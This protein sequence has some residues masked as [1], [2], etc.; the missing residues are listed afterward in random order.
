MTPPLLNMKQ[1]GNPNRCSRKKGNRENIAVEFQFRKSQNNFELS[2][3]SFYHYGVLK[4]DQ[5]LLVV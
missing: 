3:N 1:K 4:F 5:C 2:F